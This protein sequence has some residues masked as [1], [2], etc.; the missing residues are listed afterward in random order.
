MNDLEAT[1]EQAVQ[2]VKYLQ[3]NGFEQSNLARVHHN[4]VETYSKF[5]NYWDKKGKTI[6]STT[7]I[8]FAL[9]VIYIA[10]KHK[11]G[12]RNFSTLCSDALEKYSM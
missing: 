11:N 2:A 6:R 3:N 4:G 5:F 9:R 7:N 1:K 8:D 12:E 10:E